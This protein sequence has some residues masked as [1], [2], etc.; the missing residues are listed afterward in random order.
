M[1]KRYMSFTLRAV[2]QRIE[3][4]SVFMVH[5]MHYIPPDCF[6]GSPLHREARQGIDRLGQFIY[7]IQKC[8]TLIF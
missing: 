8:V 2:Y 1:Y 5:G 3:R 4:R 7:S 6:T